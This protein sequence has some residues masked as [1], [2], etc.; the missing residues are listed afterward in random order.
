MKGVLKRRLLA[1]GIS[2]VVAAGAMAAGTLP[3]HAEESSGGAKKYSF[4][5]GTLTATA[6]KEAIPEGETVGT[7]GYF[8]IKGNVTKRTNS[9]GSVKCIEVA[10]ASGGALQFTV[11]GTADV[12]LVMASTGGSNTSAVGLA[13][14]TGKIVSNTENITTVT[15]TSGTTMTYTGLGAGKYDI[16][17]PENAEYGRGARVLSVDVTE[18]GSSAGT[19]ETTGTT[20]WKT[21]AAPVVKGVTVNEN[22][23]FLVD[24]EA[25]VDKLQGGEYAM[26][27]MQNKGFEVA[28][29]KIA[30]EDRSVEM[31]PYWSGDYTFVASIYR[32][33]EA[34]KDSEPYVYKNYSMRLDKPA[35]RLLRSEGKGTVY[36]DWVDNERAKDYTVFYKKTGDADFTKAADGL[37]QGYYR[38]SGLTVGA[39]YEIKV[40]VNTDETDPQTGAKVSSEY[41]E[42]ITVTDKMEHQWY[43]GIVGSSS[44]GSMTIKEA[45]GTSHADSYGSD[46]RYTKAVD[47]TNTSGSINVPPDSSGKIS[48]DEDG[49]RYYFTLLDPNTENFKMTATFTVTDIS[50]TPDNQT[51][52][53][54]IATDIVPAN[55]LGAQ[56][57]SYRYVNSM[58]TMYYSSKNSNP[59]M[60][61]VTGNFSSNASDNETSERVNTY[62]KFSGKAS[63][64]VGNTYTFTLEKTD[65]SFIA[66][67]GDDKVTL[68]DTSILSVQDDGSICIGVMTARKVGVDITDIKFETSESKGVSGV[69]KD[70]RVKPSTRVYSTGTTGATEYEYVYASNVPGTLTVTAPD[71]K[72]LTPVKMEADS[73]ARVN[74]TLSVGD[75]TVSSTFVPDSSANLTSYDPITT[76]MNVSCKQ[77]GSLEDYL[78]VAAD[79]SGTGDGTKGNPLD[80]ATAVR[81]A[82]PG[83]ILMLKDGTY[84]GVTIERSSSGTADRYIVMRPENAGGVVFQS[85]GITLVGSYWH[86]YGMYVKNVSSVGIQI[87]GNNNIIEMCT[88]EGSTN[89][90]VQISRTGAASNRQGIVGR[91][92]PSD[93]LVKN[94]ESFDNCDSGRNDA[95]GFA[96]KLTCGEGNK[97]YGCISHNNIDDGWD[98]YAKTTSGEI[99]AVTI[100]NCVA[101]NN[102]WLSADNIADSSY[103]YGEG[104]GFKLGGGNLRGG[105]KLINSISFGNHGS[106]ITSNSCPDC[107][108]Y[109]STTYGNTTGMNLSTMASMEKSWIVQGLLSLSTADKS[110]NMPWA[111]NSVNN[112]IAMGKATYNK[113]GEEGQTSWFESVD[114]T[115]LPTRNENGT[116]NMHGLLTLNNSAP[117]DS[118]ARLDL[119]SD[120]AIS[121]MPVL[122]DFSA[123]KPAEPTA[124]PTQAPQNESNTTPAPVSTTAPS[125]NDSNKTASSNS[126]QTSENSSSSVVGWVVGIVVVVLAVGAGIVVWMRKKPKK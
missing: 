47:I 95:D 20:N 9:D 114:M 87:C 2:F 29:K 40:V 38:L 69:E 103:K 102:G 83:Q 80:L 6:D 79:G 14:A 124:Q 73:V 30:N 123:E 81:Y 42:K 32:A 34:Q 66:S 97:F 18:T 116:I 1:I 61:Y 52:F 118:G 125:G 122:R 115:V 28:S 35:F 53:G 82:M 100:E 93:N 117:A 85:K 67:M 89:T 36:V 5:P 106:G 41:S 58:S 63:F 59:G 57:G 72:A 31:I 54:I 96:A 15:S 70:E 105:H 71:G 91:L 17:T 48:D 78:Y 101:Y 24:F 111:L 64:V 8:T 4:T 76:S 99:G 19:A 27:S 22:G 51:G 25:V 49:F 126:V 75:N 120:Q 98:L 119:T 121:T 45:N 112:Y 94:C 10:K 12:V 90:G 44:R 109:N 113:L 16:I 3:V 104:N 13:D 26:I 21:V 68:D 33:G 23:N 65:T 39:E 84:N 11:T 110:D 92:W 37:T 107:E 108:I 88:V 74:V 55:L 43:A 50:Q 86:I 7:D 56:S 77:Y 60:R 62:K 46:H